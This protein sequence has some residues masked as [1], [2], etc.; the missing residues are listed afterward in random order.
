M[1]SVRQIAREAGVSITTVS[2][3]LNNHPRVSQKARERVLAAANDARYV[4]PVSK[5]STT[6]IALLYTG[7][8]SLGSPFDSQV[9][10]GM[11]SGIEEYG[12]DLM[13]LDA[14]R[15][16]QPGETYTQMFMR[17]GVRGAVLRT[18]LS[19]R[20]ICLAI[21]EE[22]FPSVVVGDRFEHPSMRFIYS[23]SREPSREAIE[24]LIALGHTRIAICLN[25]VDDSDHADRLAGYE[26]ALSDHDIPLDRKLVIRAHA[27]RT[28]GEQLMRRVASMAD[29]PTAI[30]ITDP[31]A[32]AGAF[33]EARALG[34]NVPEDISIIGFD[35][36]DLRF[37]IYPEMTAV[38]QD[39]G[40]IGQEAMTALHEV[41]ENGPGE[42]LPVRKAR[43]AWLE[44]HHSTASPSVE[45][46][47]E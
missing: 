27:N 18:T 41:I 29:R 42:T 24:H 14:K 10:W 47:A 36:G 7:E 39:T 46:R 20:H 15:S 13:V 38:C 25:I 21:A 37:D 40:A 28:G 12:Y 8:S 34:L 43:R 26:Q 3:V 31:A 11:S 22:G 45:R 35:D 44:V 23:D 1:S 33:K 32:A 19:T 9:M 17:K 30:F 16:L 5:R 2:R 4:A 6:N